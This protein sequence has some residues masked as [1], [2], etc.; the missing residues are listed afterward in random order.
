MTGNKDFVFSPGQLYRRRDLHE[1]FG[2]QRQGGIS[3]PAKARFIF[4]ITG[5]SSKQHGYSDEWT[6]DGVFL[7][8][9]KDSTAT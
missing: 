1:R 2:G 8:T 5:D 4:L 3:T 7:Y 9:G 6:P